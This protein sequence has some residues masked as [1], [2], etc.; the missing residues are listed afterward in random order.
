MT[1]VLRSKLPAVLV[2]HIKL[3]TGEGLWRNNKYIHIH[4]I[5]RDDF[6][7]AILKCMPK[8]KQVTNSSDS[9]E[10]PKRGCVWFKMPT[11]KF[12]VITVRYCHVRIGHQMSIQSYTWEMNYNEKS[13]ILLI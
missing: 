6:R 1:Y 10:H 11:G 8:I 2:D 9:K 13:L 3:Y 4:P 12:V 7:Y 5:P